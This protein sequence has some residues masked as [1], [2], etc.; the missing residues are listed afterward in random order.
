L[1]TTLPPVGVLFLFFLF[2]K[3]MV[4]IGARAGFSFRL[5]FFASTSL[6]GDLVLLAVAGAPL[7]WRTATRF[8]GRAPKLFFFFCQSTA[9]M[10][11]IT[12]T[13]CR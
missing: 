11:G 9:V 8:Y 4:I 2:N 10:T 3:K 7:L 6:L 13:L 5:F 1:Q 12:E